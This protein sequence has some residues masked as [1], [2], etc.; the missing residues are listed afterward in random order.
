MGGDL[1][2]PTLKPVGDLRIP[3]V[4]PVSLAAARDKEIGIWLEGGEREF[5]TQLRQFTRAAYRGDK[6]IWGRVE[7]CFPGNMRRPE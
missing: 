2:I 5:A 4:R 1:L 6:E 7:K 3:R